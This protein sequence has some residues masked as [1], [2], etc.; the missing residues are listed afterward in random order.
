MTLR[1]YFAYPGEKGFRNCMDHLIYQLLLDPGVSEDRTG[2]CRC[3]AH[4]KTLK[5]NL[6]L[7]AESEC[8][9]QPTK[10]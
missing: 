2:N 6:K 9:A 8:A 3:D 10:H 1:I 4:V 5:N 7:F